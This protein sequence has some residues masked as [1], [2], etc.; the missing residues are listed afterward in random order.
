ME[1]EGD[2]R[3]IYLKFGINPFN[4]IKELVCLGEDTGMDSLQKLKIYEVFR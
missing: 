3:N 2:Y 1:S 4:L